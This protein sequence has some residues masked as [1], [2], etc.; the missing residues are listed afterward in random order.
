MPW[1]AQ[2]LCVP[3]AP[4]PHR[5]ES[6]PSRP[7]TLA[8][9]QTAAR[10]RE[11][12]K[13]TRQTPNTT[14]HHRSPTLRTDDPH[15]ANAQPQSE[16]REQQAQLPPGLAVWASPLSGSGCGRGR[17]RVCSAAREK[18]LASQDR[19][20]NVT[21]DPPGIAAVDQHVGTTHSETAAARYS[22]P[23]VWLAGFR[24]TPVRG[25]VLPPG[26][27]LCAEL[28]TVAGRHLRS[29]LSSFPPLAPPI[30]QFR[31]ARHGQPLASA[32][33]SP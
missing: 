33:S 18:G 8:S 6:S 16:R 9:H 28:G 12:W 21:L 22:V 19:G 15:N 7:H 20:L 25:A 17:A 5:L 11:R 4:S 26:V 3:A 23:P 24:R 30:A 13:R 32:P 31:G 14:S 10:F 2:R 1:R 29:V 27:L